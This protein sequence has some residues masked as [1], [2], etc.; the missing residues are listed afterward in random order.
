MALR[1]IKANEVATVEAFNLDTNA[2]AGNYGESQPVFK[3]TFNQG[4][5]LV[6]KAELAASDK[7]RKEKSA[8]FGALLMEA[9][10]P[11]VKWE[12]IKDSENTELLNIAD[13]KYRPNNRAQLTKQFLA[14]V[15]GAGIFFMTKMA[16]IDNLRTAKG[17]LKK[18]TD[19]EDDVKLEKRAKSLVS[20][21]SKP[22]ALNQLGKIIAVDLFI[23]NYDRF[24]ENGNV[25]NLGNVMFEKLDDKSYKPV[26]LDHLDPNSTFSDL[27]KR[28]ELR[29]WAGR[30]LTDRVALGE[31]AVRVIQSVNAEIRAKVPNIKPG[32]LLNQTQCGGPLISGLEDGARLLRER[33]VALRDSGKAIPTGAKQRMEALGW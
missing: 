29:N 14:D 5:P 9:V 33:L 25:V 22:A 21:M 23:G 1:V 6:V 2:R 26:G 4:E 8:A 31:L 28:V 17:K 24:D 32:D 7:A 16:F 3:L 20:K 11:E 18:K 13:N 15:M 30:K 19:D 10:S 27:T 12:R